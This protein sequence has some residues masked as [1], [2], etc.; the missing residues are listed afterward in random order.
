MRGE[1]VNPLSGIGT[2]ND[3]PSPKMPQVMFV[4]GGF[5]DAELA[6]MLAAPEG[7]SIPWV[8]P[9]QEAREEVRRMGDLMSPEQRAKGPGE[10]VMEVVVR[11]VKGCLR[12]RGVVEGGEGL[13]GVGGA[14][15]RC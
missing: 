3:N 10:G 7:K 11:Q 5:T 14:M 8:S 15:W 1:P 6:E 13:K 4:G 2:N 9:G 12:E